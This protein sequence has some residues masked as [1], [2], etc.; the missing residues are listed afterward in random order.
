MNA[1]HLIN[2]PIKDKV[3]FVDDEAFVLFSIRRLFRQNNIEVDVETDSVKALEMIR[4]NTYKVIISDYRMPNMNGAE[5]LEM[6]KDISPQSIRLVLSAQ[7]TPTGLQD[8]IN[9]CEVHRFI[10]KPWQDQ[11]LLEIVK[12]S[13]LKYN[14]LQNN[15]RDTD[16]E[17]TKCDNVIELQILKEE[18]VEHDKYIENIIPSINFE[19]L[20]LKGMC[21]NLRKE[22]H[23]HLNYIINLT[24]NR[25][26]NHC[27]RVSQLST[28]FGKVLKLDENQQKNLYLAS[29]Y[30]DIGK[31]FEFVA[32]ADHS[33][34]GANILSQFV[35]LK[36]AA[37]IVQYHHKRIDDEGGSNL[38]IES[39]I[40]AIVDHFDKEVT[41][42][43][44][45]EVD[46]KPRTLSEILGEMLEQRN[47]KFDVELVETFKE[48]ILKDFKLDSFFN[49]KKIHITELEVGMVLS[50]PLLNIQ[51][52][53]LMN[54]EYIMSKEV[55]ARLFKHHEIIPINGPIF[56]YEKAPEKGFNFEEMIGKKIK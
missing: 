50:R 14:N 49:E 33:E 53:M 30:H 8:I 5:F 17:N 15:I 51:G 25:I 10:N 9:K 45:R 28:Y 20:D 11:N 16:L 39:K 41:K 56:V 34:L 1:E 2:N 55:I 37:K 54:S 32:Q 22:Q 18:N 27:K 42:E 29:L 13:I 12:A 24:S 31:L 38:P 6:V 47:K 35:E 43:F 26:A 44:N 48:V 7:I 36:E 52:K 4:E 23:Q 40:L 19:N 46:E 3:L 21:D